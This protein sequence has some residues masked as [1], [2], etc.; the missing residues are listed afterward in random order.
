MSER[1]GI[2]EYVV[3][4]QIVSCDVVTLR[5]VSVDGA[6]NS[7]KVNCSLFITPMSLVLRGRLVQ[8]LVCT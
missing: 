5:I 6:G 1:V 4:I 7:T 2:V 8:M 3:K